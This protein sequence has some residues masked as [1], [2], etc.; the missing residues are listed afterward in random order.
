VIEDLAKPASAKKI[1]DVARA[2]ADQ[3]RAGATPYSSR[4]PPFPAAA[5]PATCVPWPTD[6]SESAGSPRTRSPPCEW[7]W[8]VFAEVNRSVHVHQDFDLNGI[9]GYVRSGL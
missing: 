6:V 9:V 8:G 3:V 5:M 4:F 7:A 1:E 2:D